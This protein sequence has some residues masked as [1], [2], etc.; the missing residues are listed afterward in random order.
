MVLRIRQ[1]Y[2]FN[3]TVFFRF[4]TLWGN[5][6]CVCECEAAAEHK[7]E[8]FPPYSLVL[9]WLSFQTSAESLS[10]KSFFRGCFQLSSHYGSWQFGTKL[11]TVKGGTHFQRVPVLME[12]RWQ[13][14]SQQ[15]HRSRC[16]M[17]RKAALLFLSS[18]I[19]RGRNV[20]QQS[21]PL[22]YCC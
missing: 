6:C 5:F 11:F 9:C 14:H 16:K 12:R 21:F 13:E 8:L 22:K 1:F 7:D 15:T 2:S 18:L 10:D 20:W 17:W 3:A 4:A 19:S